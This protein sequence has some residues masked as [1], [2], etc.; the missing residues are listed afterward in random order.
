MEIIWFFKDSIYHIKH[1]I[2]NIEN[3]I[4]AENYQFINQRIF[5]KMCSCL[6]QLIPPEWFQMCFNYFKRFFLCSL[7]SKRAPFSVILKNIKRIGR[8]NQL[9]FISANLHTSTAL[10]IYFISNWDKLVPNTFFFF[11]LL[12]C[13]RVFLNPLGVVKGGSKIL[14]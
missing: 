13:Q 7:I 6:V 5:L 12:T 2:S 9:I 14:A 1:A 3:D 4:I 8:L 10:L 11:Y